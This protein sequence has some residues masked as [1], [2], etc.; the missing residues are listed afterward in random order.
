MKLEDMIY[1]VD[2]YIN[3]FNSWYV[4][5]IKIDDKKGFWEI[6]KPGS[7]IEKVCLFSDE[8]HMCIYGDYGSYVFDKMTWQGTPYNLEYNNLPYQNGKMSFD[9][10]KAVYVFDEDEVVEDIISWLKEIAVVLYDYTEDEMN[11]LAEKIC[12][13]EPYFNIYDFCYENDCGDLIH[14]LDFCYDLYQN[15]SDEY[16]FISCLRDSNFPNLDY[17]EESCRSYLWSAGKRIRQDYLVS[18]LALKICGEKLR[19]QN[20]NS[21]LKV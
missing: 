11:S 18:L 1:N 21:T 5:E 2:I 19:N 9:T 17:F 3:K 13:N 14:L 12:F 10:K 16:N 20:E 15:S 8:Y 6:R 4:K 7:E